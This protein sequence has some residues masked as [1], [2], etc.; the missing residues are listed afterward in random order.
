MSG[1]EHIFTTRLFGVGVMLAVTQRILTMTHNVSFVYAEDSKPISPTWANPAYRWR[2]AVE[3]T[4]TTKDAELP[5]Q[6]HRTRSEKPAPCP[7]KLASNYVLVC[8]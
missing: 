5:S 8:I 4:T 3:E 2:H 1:G 7:R 6:G